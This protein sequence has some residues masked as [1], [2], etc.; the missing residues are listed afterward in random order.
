MFYVLLLP[1]IFLT[2][3]VASAIP[4]LDDKPLSYRSKCCKCS[5]PLWVIRVV[6]VAGQPLPFYLHQPISSDRL[7]RFV[8]TAAT[9]I[10]YQCGPAIRPDRGK[11]H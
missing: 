2:P 1:R 11:M 7:V 3:P 9:L 10:Y 8:P 4:I 6:L 5:E